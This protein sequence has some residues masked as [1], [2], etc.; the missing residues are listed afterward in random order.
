MHTDGHVLRSTSADGTALTAAVA[1]SGPPLVMVHGSLL[2]RHHLDL[3]AAELRSSMTTYAMDRRGFGDSG[4]ADAYDIGREFDDVAAVV[5]H[6]AALT[7]EPVTLFGHSYGASCAMGGAARSENVAALILYEPSL[8]L[9]YPDGLIESIEAAVRA[10]DSS[11]AGDV[12]LREILE[13]SDE[14]VL[15]THSTDEWNEILAN[16]HTIAREAYAEQ[17]WTY[18]PAQFAS[19]TAPTVLLSGTGS[20]PE[21]VLA[22]ERAAAAIAGAVIRPIHGHGH[23]ATREA[24]DLVARVILDAVYGT[25]PPHTR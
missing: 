15:E 12:V 25:L 21:L 8:G 5:D 1:G 14:E 23:T 20:P 16:G 17:G 18:R 13:M 2:G 10:G 11:A 4:D 9:S 19:I 24:P 6:V 7:G 3:L 22:T